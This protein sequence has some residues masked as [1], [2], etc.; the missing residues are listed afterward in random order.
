MSGRGNAM[1]MALRIVLAILL[2]V[3]L[4]ALILAALWFDSG[5]LRQF[6]IAVWSFAG[7]FTLAG[8]L[9]YLD[10]VFRG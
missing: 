9:V 8:I 5:T 4:V 2:I 3:M 6:N 7:A 10:K 1:K